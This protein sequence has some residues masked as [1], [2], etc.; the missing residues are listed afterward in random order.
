MNVRSAPSP[1]DQRPLSGR[2][3]WVIFTMVIL[4]GVLLIEPLWVR[5]ASLYNA[6]ISIALIG[7]ISLLTLSHARFGRVLMWSS[8]AAIISVLLDLFMSTDRL[9]L[10]YQSTRLLLAI[11]LSLVFVIL[12]ARNFSS[13]DIRTKIILGILLAGGAA[14]SIFSFFV[15]AQASRLASSLSGRLEASVSSLAEEQLINTV[16]TQAEAANQAFTDVLDSVQDLA[17]NWMMLQAQKDVLGQGQYWDATTA[18]SQ[19]EGGQYGNSASDVSSLF[20]PVGTRL[21]GSLIADMNTSAYLDFQA[22]AIL[23]NNTAILAVYAI[24]TKGVTRYYPNIEL[25]T[26]L[27]PD[28]DATQR[29]YYQISIPLL[30]PRRA[31][32]WT[33][34]YVDATGGGLVVTVAIPVYVDDQFNGVV[35]GDMQLSKITEQISSI[36]VGQTGYAF[37]VDGAGRLLSM[38]PAGFQ[39]FGMQEKDVN[40]EEFLQA[41]IIGAGNAELKDTTARMIAG[42]S[43]LIITNVG[44]VD[45]YVTFAPIKANDYSLAVVVPVAE[46]Q[47]AI[48]AARNETNALLDSSVKISAVLL[49]VLLLVS[50]LISL[51]IGQLIAS[52]IVTLTRVANQ[53]VIGDLAAQAKVSSKDE[54]G[55]LADA[56]NT[57][58]SRLRETLL[59]L[60]QRVEER[61]SELRIA[62][63]RNERRARQF[64]AIAQIASTI[65]TTRNLDTLLTQVT[66]AISSRFGFYHVGIF[67]LDTRREYA[68]LSAANSEGGQRMLARRHKLRVGETGI[69]GFVTQTGKA[70]IALSTG[71]DAV[72]FNNPDLPE[73]H[74]E[75]ALPLLVENIVIGALDV[76]STQPNAFNQD[77]VNILTTLADQVSVAIQNSR[78]YDET[79]R[80]LAEADAISRQFVQSGWKQFTRSQNLLGVHHTGAKATLLYTNNGANKDAH[81]PE[82]DRTRNQRGSFISLPVKLRGETIGTVD[83]R[84]PDKQNWDQDDLDVVQAIIERAAIA[85]ENARL[86]AESQKRAAKE[87]TIGEISAKISAQSDIDEL[88]KTAAQELN[89]TLPGAEIAIQLHNNEEK[90]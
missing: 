69:V 50:V 84:S 53:I 11:S 5:G 59:G 62:N 82:I 86:L 30:N 7:S 42:E 31:P 27:P 51:G 43:G 36:T 4:G 19:L 73:T 83:V 88:L 80:A 37:M 9:P 54:I 17:E 35:A 10:T 23:Q 67:L 63:E 85:M 65:T 46:L 38:P 77:D 20:V 56:F 3:Q 81:Q 15:V 18:L 29:P 13:F 44:G 72:F 64:E 2:A 90:Q 74:S 76:Q 47:T 25:A 33:I 52:P 8:I 14:L 40:S 61:S 55:N 45:Y 49:I 28:F 48:V 68:V 70:R 60:E 58:T 16:N 26:L 12:L 34:P 78:Q 41:T 24:D 87:R 6:L 39:L 21:S 75:I 32:R 22:P 71:E 66:T 79:Q 89:R 1:S 57:M